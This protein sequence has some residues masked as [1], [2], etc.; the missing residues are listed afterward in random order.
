MGVLHRTDHFLDYIFLCSII[1]GYS[2][3]VS[4][5]NDQLLLGVLALLSAFMVHT[6]LAF[7]ATNEFHISF[8]NMGPTEVRI[9]CIAFNTLV[10]I[11]G[12]SAVEIYLGEFLAIGSGALLL[13]ISISQRRMWQIDMRKQ[14]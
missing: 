2:F 12:M 4:P 6:F 1:F 14:S 9:V 8:M 7:N 3:L 5:E 10:I 11:F 13:T